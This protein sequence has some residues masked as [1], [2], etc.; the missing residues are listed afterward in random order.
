MRR[1]EYLGRVD[2]IVF[3]E[4]PREG[5]FKD[6]QFYHPDLRFR[7]TFP[8]GWKTLKPYMRVVGQPKA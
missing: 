8:G 6:A 1:P 2:G 7:M 3:G 5:Y 4:N